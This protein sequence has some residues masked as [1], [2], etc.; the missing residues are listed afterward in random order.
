MGSRALGFTWTKSPQGGDGG[1]GVGGVVGIPVKKNPEN[2][3]VRLQSIRV[4][5]DK[6]STRGDGG[7]GVGGV[8]GI[9]VKRK[10]NISV[11]LQNIRVHLD[12]LSTRRRWWCWCWWGCGYTCEKKTERAT[13]IYS[14]A[15]PEQC[16]YSL[17]M[18][19]P[20]R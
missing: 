17:K 7:V 2:I 20:S 10:Q 4:H 15:C 9:P 12:K 1:V 18:R 16:T 5:L 13:Q 8:V 19:I 14:V 6:V 11:R 3:S